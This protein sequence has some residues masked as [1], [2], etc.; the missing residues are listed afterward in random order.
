[1]RRVLVIGSG[2]AGKTTFA[3]ALAERT[4][5]PLIHLD[6]LFW[7]AGWT[8]TPNE[9]WDRTI[10]QLLARETWIMDG[11]YGRTLP[12]RLAACDTV[13]FLDMPRLLS[14]WRVLQRSVRYRGR[15]RPDLPAGCP[16]QITR[17]FVWWIWTYKARRRPGILK[18]LATLPADTRAIVLR[19]SREAREFL[20]RLE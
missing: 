5:L 16:E 4:G 10:E 11:N 1:M 3:K 6:T 9:A 19:S 8:P 12:T 18:Q 7:S 14:L 15:S 13:I 20:D 17:E 2:G